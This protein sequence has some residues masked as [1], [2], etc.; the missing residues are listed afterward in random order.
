M[1]ECFLNTQRA[2][3]LPIGRLPRWSEWLDIE[4]TKEYKK[5]LKAIN[6][7]IRLISSQTEGKL[8]GSKKDC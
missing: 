7:N 6:S 1:K 3:V 5:G 2:L 4:E 8:W